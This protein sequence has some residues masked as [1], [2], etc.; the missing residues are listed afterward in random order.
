MMM[1]QISEQQMPFPFSF[2]ACTGAADQ[3]LSRRRAECLRTALQGGADPVWSQWG[4]VEE[5]LEDV[6]AHLSVVGGPED[7]QVPRLVDCH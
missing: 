7:V 3:T 4:V 1:D 2:Q 5:L 6:S